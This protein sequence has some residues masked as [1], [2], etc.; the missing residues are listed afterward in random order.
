MDIGDVC[1]KVNIQNDTS[2]AQR[3]IA[4]PTELRGEIERH[5]RASYLAGSTDGPRSFAI[6]VR[7]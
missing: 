4:L 5:V 6:I 7:G 2:I 3:L 1:R